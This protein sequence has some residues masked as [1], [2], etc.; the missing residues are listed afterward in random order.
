[1]PDTGHRTSRR[2]DR[3]HPPADRG[4][5]GDSAVAPALN[6]LH[7]AALRDRTPGHVLRRG[8]RQPKDLM[9]R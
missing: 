9:L 4:R 3:D 2:F 7:L 6:T 5:D 8:R 1:M